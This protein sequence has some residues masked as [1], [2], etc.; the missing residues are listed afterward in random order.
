MRKRGHLPAS[1][2]HEQQKK[3]QKTNLHTTN[4]Q[5]SKTPHQTPNKPKPTPRHIIFNDTDFSNSTRKTTGFKQQ[6]VASGVKPWKPKRPVPTSRGP[7][8]SSELAFDGE[9]DFPR[10]WGK[11]PEEKQNKKKKK[12]NKARQALLFQSDGHQDSKSNHLFNMQKLASKNR[13]GEKKKNW[14]NYTKK[15]DARVYYEE[16]NLFI[17]KQ[18]RRKR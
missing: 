9:E 5:S 1:S 2:R 18:R 13:K 6:Q 7:L 16:D 17:I 3:K 10:G 15:V 4:H 8:P 11:Q 12:M 14:K